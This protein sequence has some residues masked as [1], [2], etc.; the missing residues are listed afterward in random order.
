MSLIVGLLLGPWCFALLAAVFFVLVAFF[1]AALT[2]AA[3]IRGRRNGRDQF[4]A[5]EAGER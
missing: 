2:L 1:W 3:V 4:A 5:M